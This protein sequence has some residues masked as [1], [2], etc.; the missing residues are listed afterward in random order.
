MKRKGRSYV[1]AFLT[2]TPDLD[3]DGLTY[4]LINRRIIPVSVAT[5]GPIPGPAA[6]HTRRATAR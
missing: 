5:H 4:S 3:D 1:N 6:S 2:A